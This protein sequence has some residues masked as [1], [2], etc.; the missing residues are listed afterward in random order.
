MHFQAIQCA[1]SHLA[2]FQVKNYNTELAL[3]PAIDTL[4]L[5]TLRHLTR[6]AEDYFDDQMERKGLY[7]EPDSE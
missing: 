3:D 2:V 4:A 7:E 1:K 5:Y 6:M